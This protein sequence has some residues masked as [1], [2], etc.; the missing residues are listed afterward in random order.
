MDA[1]GAIVVA[2]HELFRVVLP[3]RR[4]DLNDDA[5]VLP[6]DLKLEARR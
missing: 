4:V 5:L 1:P 3:E 6:R 2:P